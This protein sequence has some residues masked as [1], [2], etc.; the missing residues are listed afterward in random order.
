MRW[1]VI[2]LWGVVAG[3]LLRSHDP[4]YKTAV[5]VRELCRS[6]DGL[7]HLIRHQIAVGYLDESHAAEDGAVVSLRFSSVHGPSP[8]AV[9]GGR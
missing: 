8:M 9:G 4:A 1:A 5:A 2:P 7:R 3:G 6:D